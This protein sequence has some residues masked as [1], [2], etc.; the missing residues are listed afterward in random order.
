MFIVFVLV[1]ISVLI[2]LLGN[3]FSSFFPFYQHFWDIQNYYTSYYGAV[4]SLERWFL[5]TR[6]K[7]PGREG[8]WWWQWSTSLEIPSDVLS[9]TFWFFTQWNNGLRREIRSRR[10]RV[11]D[12]TQ[13][14]NI[15]WYTQW[16]PIPL[17]MDNSP[18]SSGYQ[19]TS[20]SDLVLFSWTYLSWTF[21]LSPEIIETLWA[22]CDTDTWCSEI[23]LIWMLSWS[24]T[25]ITKQFLQSWNSLLFSGTYPPILFDT[26]YLFLPNFLR[27][28]TLNA[29]YPFVEYVLSSDHAFSD[30]FFTIIWKWIVGEYET[31]LMIKKPVASLLN[32]YI[33][34]L[35]FP[36]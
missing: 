13:D 7:L 25:Y 26:L 33:Q 4:S 1:L 5:V 23:A 19:A 12:I 2:A 35:L 8:S 11:P 3:I 27:N 14:H 28:V 21:K 16:E 29:L 9:G 17:Y 6:Y 15:L 34:L 18:A 24:N 32:P 22:I 10:T 31:T 36:F 20:L 30:P